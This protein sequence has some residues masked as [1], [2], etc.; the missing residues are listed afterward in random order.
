[1]SGVPDD[2]PPRLGLRLL[3]K[4]GAAML[5][6][7][8]LCAA[9]VATATMTTPMIGGSTDPAIAV[10]WVATQSASAK[11]PT[12]ASK[13]MTR[14]SARPSTPAAARI[15]T[16]PGGATSKMAMPLR[17]ARRERPTRWT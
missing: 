4:A 7:T 16:R 12:G 2:R 5:V 1:M 11:A 13:N 14:R 3:L 17:P 8:L 9:S 10:T 6:I 15:S